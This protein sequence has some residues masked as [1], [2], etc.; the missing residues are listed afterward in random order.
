M[1]SQ[2]TYASVM[3]SVLLVD[4]VCL[5]RCLPIAHLSCQIV[6]DF[7]MYYICLDGA[8]GTGSLCCVVEVPCLVSLST[9]SFLGILEY[10]N[11]QESSI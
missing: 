6:R 5:V 4:R 3:C 7:T 8:Q 2:V 11:V 10:R 1:C 9:L